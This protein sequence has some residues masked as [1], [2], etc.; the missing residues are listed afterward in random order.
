MPAGARRPAQYPA[1]ARTQEAEKSGKKRWPD[2]VAAGAVANNNGAVE[3][4]EAKWITQAWRRR[5]WP[6]G[7]A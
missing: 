7:N 3:L 1:Q 5:V 4:A 6:G 2:A